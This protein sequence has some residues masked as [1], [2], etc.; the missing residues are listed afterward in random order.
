MSRHDDPL[1][2]RFWSAGSLRGLA[3]KSVRRL[4]VV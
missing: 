4:I 1:R 2:K 3:A